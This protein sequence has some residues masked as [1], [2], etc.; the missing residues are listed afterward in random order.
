LRKSYNF[1][2]AQVRQYL[3]RVAKVVM[4]TTKALLSRGQSSSENIWT[5]VCGTIGT[6]TARF[7]TAS[8]C[9]F[10]EVSQ[11]GIL[12]KCST[13]NCTEE[14]HI[15]CAHDIGSIRATEGDI[16]S[17]FTVQCETHFA[18]VVYCICH[19][20]Y[21]MDDQDMINWY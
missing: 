3:A 16:G 12:V 5:K 7:S 13:K 8:S 6:N 4:R 17:M 10:C 1:N 19:S 18:P 14:L 21:E 2:T 15:E 20:P 9:S 11:K